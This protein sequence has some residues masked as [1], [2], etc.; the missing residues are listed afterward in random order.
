MICLLLAISLCDKGA[1]KFTNDIYMG[2]SDDWKYYSTD[3]I[4][5]DIDFDEL[6][7]R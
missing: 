5:I 1:S 3:G 2:E 6:N 7:L 4:Y